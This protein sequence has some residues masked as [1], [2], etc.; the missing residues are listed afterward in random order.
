MNARELKKTFPYLTITKMKSSR[1]AYRTERGWLKKL[2]K[3]NKERK[4]EC[5]APFV[6]HLEIEIT[7]KKSRT[8]GLCPHAEARWKD[9]EGWHYDDK[10]GS[11]S[12]CG[13]DKLSQ[14]VADVMNTILTRNLYEKR[15][16]IA[17]KSKIPGGVPY[18]L[19]TSEYH[20]LPWFMGAVGINCYYECIEFLGGKMQCVVVSRYYEKYVIDFKRPKKKA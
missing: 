3:L 9:T 7:W 17:T 1:N 18:G 13:Y 12:G 16:K 11:A 5:E 6:I 20:V 14:C 10:A 19:T 2:E 8:W 15:R 4:Q